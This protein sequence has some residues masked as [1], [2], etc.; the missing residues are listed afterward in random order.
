MR[1]KILKFIILTV[2]VT[3]FLVPTLISNRSALTAY[4]DSPAPQVSYKI[5][6]E[7]GNKVFYMTVRGEEDGEYLP[8]GLYYNTGENIYLIE[9]EYF[10]SYESSTILSDDGLCFASLPWASYRY[11]H[12]RLDG[13]AIQFFKNGVLIKEYATGQLLRNARKAEYSVSHMTWEK[14]Q[15]RRFDSSGNLLYVTTNDG[16]EYCFDLSTGLATGKNKPSETPIKNTMFNHSSDTDPNVD[17][18]S[19]K[20]NVNFGGGCRAASIR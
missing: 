16:I 2:L 19:P 18:P 17:T 10:Y 11:E 20:P 15:E 3:G 5:E 7:D 13:I 1:L 9:S 14:W 8:S 12:D 6:L 4:A